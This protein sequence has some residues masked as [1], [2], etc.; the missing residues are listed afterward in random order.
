MLNNMSRGQ[1]WCNIG[2]VR[3]R[4]GFGCGRG[5]MSWEGGG[6]DGGGGGGG[7]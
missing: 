2:F 1:T 6:G 5:P 7:G 3:R 4:G